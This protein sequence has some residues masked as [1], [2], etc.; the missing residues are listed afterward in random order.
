MKKLFLFTFCILFSF[1]QL[2]AQYDRSKRD[3]NKD[4]STTTQQQ[5]QSSSSDKNDEE[6]YNSKKGFDKRKMIYGGFIFPSFWNGFNIDATALVGYRV[7]KK[8]SAGLSSNFYYSS[9]N[10]PIIDY[11]GN[12]L[13]DG[14]SSTRLIGGGVW[15]K[16]L[17]FRNLL[18][19]LAFEQN[20]Y[21]YNFQIPNNTFIGP[22][23]WY[24]SVLAGVTYRQ[25][26]A[27]RLF[28]NATLLYDLLQQNP[29]YSK[30]F[31]YRV[32]FSSAF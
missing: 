17:L 4:N 24:P 21:R 30:T 27:G 6:E 23:T 3:D 13:G 14:S 29:V 8:L 16:Y 7:T 2:F 10:G 12:N 20:N 31:I 26:V 32:G 25:Q 28:F 22:A 18:A 9:Y 19:N 11:Y 1:T 5:N 15:A